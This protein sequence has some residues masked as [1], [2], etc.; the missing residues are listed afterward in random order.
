MESDSKDEVLIGNPVEGVDL[1][2][3]APVDGLIAGAGAR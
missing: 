1:D 3:E 2:C